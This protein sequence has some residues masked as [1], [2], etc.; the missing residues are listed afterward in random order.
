MPSRVAIIDDS[1]SDLLFTS[2]MVQRSLDTDEVLTFES[3]RDALAYL[4]R[5]EGHQIGVILLDINMPGMGGFE[6]LEV[7]ETLPAHQRADAVVVML[8]SSPDPQ[9]RA[10]AFSFGSVKGYLVKPIDV[11]SARGLT[12]WC[13]GLRHDGA[14]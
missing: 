7:Y 12:R 3:A 6:F 10:R 13:K 11:E 14:S 4:Q 9:D 5:P 2:I 8:T 1:E